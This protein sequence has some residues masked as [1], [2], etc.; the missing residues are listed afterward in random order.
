MSL[1]KMMPVV[2]I[3]A[4]CL[5]AVM[6][7]G[8]GA[9]ADELNVPADHPT[10]QAG[11]N[12][13]VDGDTV[14]VADGTYTGAGNKTLQFAGRAITVRS[15]NGPD[16]CI[17]DCQGAGL[18]FYFNNTGESYDSV[19][20]GFTITNGYWSGDGGGIHC[21]GV[22]P[23][24]VNCIIADNSVA[25]SGGGIY[26]NNADPVISNCKIT[27]NHA[28]YN[29]GGG[30]IA[31]YHSSPTITNCAIVANTAALPGWG[32]GILLYGDASPV[33][34]NCLVSDNVGVRGGGIAMYGPFTGNPTITNCTVAGNIV[35]STP[36]IPG[37]GDGL[38]VSTGGSPTL[39]NCILWDNP[40][41]EIY[42]SF[43]SVA[44]TYSDVAGGW[45]GDGNLDADPEFVDPANGD[46]RLS[47]TSP[48]IDA[49]TNS[50]DDLPATDLDGEQRVSC[51]KV[52]LGAYES[53]SG[54]GATVITC[55]GDATL[56]YPAADTTPTVTGLA[57]AVG[58]CGG[59]SIPTTYIDTLIADCG[60]GV[61]IERTWSATDGAGQTASCVQI[62]TVA[63][64]TA[65]VII[66][67]DIAVSGAFGGALV[68][69]DPWAT[70]NGLGEPVVTTDIASG[71]FFE[72]GV[73][74]VTAT[75]TDACDNSSTC[76]FDVIVS[77]F[78]VNDAKIGT[79]PDRCRGITLLEVT[80][81]DDAEQLVGLYVPEEGHDKLSNSTVVDDGVNGPQTID[82]SCPRP[83][84]IGD[85]FGAYTVTDLAKLFDDE[86]ASKGNKL[87]IRGAF[88]PA[89]PIDLAVDDVTFTV[90]DGYGHGFSF[91]IPAGSFEVDGNPEK[92]KFK[93]HSPRESAVDIKAKFEL[94]RCSFKLDVKGVQGTNDLVGTTVTIGL[95]VGASAGQEVVEMEDKR[96][97]LK[98]KQSPKLECCPAC[99]GIAFM[100]VTS[101]QGV[102]PFEPEPG[103]EKLPP[104]V[105]VDD[106]V[107]GPMTIPTS[108]SQPI[109]VGD[110]FG[111]YTVSELVKVFEN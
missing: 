18:G 104:H 60:G 36:Q 9:F 92:A 26:C 62:I 48:C 66:C 43:A 76:T 14:V 75:A 99:R 72:T 78:G 81:T 24:I 33:I 2:S 19:V 89:L 79:K 7:T 95:A 71:S 34:V 91:L 50:A 4:S 20:N 73:T 68:T 3:V 102:F 77:C 12:A 37:L 65:P 110:V 101:D 25:H 35:L 31:L 52:D 97:H 10:I 57:T 85:V 39:T 84:E 47:D 100:Q 5:M 6:P 87:S 30:G 109:D 27:G 8:G 15:A 56:E 90:D 98:F 1:R 80:S 11:I 41:D 106:G 108:G 86:V 88:S 63:D 107:N 82:T 103:H 51:D 42:P 40:L 93:F 17:I 58:G 111:P 16:N 45:A 105:V 46:F 13:A 29:H 69:F 44:I 53:S 23:T 59:Q 32:G 96:N 94:G 74:T 49:G 70:D 67:E 21:V 38:Y 54:T 28:G 64:T 22:S 83:I 61:T 55:P